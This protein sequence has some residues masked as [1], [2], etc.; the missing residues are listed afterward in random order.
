VTTLYPCTAKQRESQLGHFATSPKENHMTLPKELLYLVAAS[1][2]AIIG[3]AF[4]VKSRRL[5]NLLTGPAFLIGL[6][7]HLS[8]DGWHGLLTSFS[9]ALICGVI[10]LVFYLAGGMGAGDV[11]M[12]TAVGCIAGLPNISYLMVLT[13]LA[14]GV[15][16]VGL[17]LMRGR[18]K[19]TLFNVGALASHHAQSGLKPHPEHNVLN[20]STLRLPYGLAIAAGA[21]ITLYLQGMP[22]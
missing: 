1:V 16:A 22:R 9:A 15:M 10:F 20:A 2:C 8:L 18:L 19:E 12:I 14:G 21:T 3:A 6:V 11:K 7:L 17:A 5:P 4:D 13:A